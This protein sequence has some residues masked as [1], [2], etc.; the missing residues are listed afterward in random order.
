V[1]HRRRPFRP[2]AAALA[3]LALVAASC[4]DDDDDD[5]AA[6]ASDTSAAATD[7][8]AA[9]AGD[10]AGATSSL[11][12][13]Y[14]AWPGWFPLAVA[15]QQGLFTAAGLDV[16]LRYFADYTASLDALVAG[17][18]DVNAQTLNDTIFA[19]ASGAAQQVVVVNDNSTGNDQIIC[20]EAITSVEGLAG[21]TIAA[22]PG[23]V[24]HFLLL[25]G[26][27]EAGLTEDDIDFQGVKTDAAAAAFAGGEF[28]C[29]GVFAPFTLVALERPGS[30]VV[31][32]SADFPGV[33]PD[34][35]VATTEAAEDAEAMQRLVTAWYA[36]LDWI[37]ANPEDATAIMAEVAGTTVEEY[38]SF[39]AGTTLFTAEQA[40]DAFEDR[41]GDP[42]SLPEMA[43][44][45]N[46]FLVESGLAEEEADL[47]GLFAPQFTEAFVAQ[48]Q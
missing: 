30:Q 17:Q 47:T 36:T 48:A 5:G 28:D 41:P 32:S 12:I 21:A 19:V 39:E 18:L 46:P 31:F 29:V 40:L 8:T 26:L 44:R 4:G 7:T 43:R 20:D 37:T 15:D 2:L 33:I 23:V 25:Q 42:T 22:E 16:D 34:H 13:G 10:T 27:A 35:L 6:G 1:A 11:T 9:G 45:I 24:D 38:Q 14:S 3:V